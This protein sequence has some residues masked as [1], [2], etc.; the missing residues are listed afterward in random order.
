MV[1]LNYQ[2][3]SLHISAIGHSITS[4][5]VHLLPWSHRAAGK[6]ERRL[7]SPDGCATK[8]ALF[9]IELDDGKIFTGKPYIVLYLMVKTHGFPVKI[10][11]LNQSNEFFHVFPHLAEEAAPADN[12]ASDGG[13]DPHLRRIRSTQ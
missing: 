3:V 12:A 6:A 1:M 9:F 2:R 7:R 10:F 4:A 5:A 11:P 8:A 13:P